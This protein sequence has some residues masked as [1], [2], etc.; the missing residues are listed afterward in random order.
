MIKECH[1]MN[2]RIV[3]AKKKFTVCIREDAR[4]DLEELVVKKSKTDGQ[5]ITITDYLTFLVQK[6]HKQINKPMMQPA[7]TSLLSYK[8][9]DKPEPKETKPK[10]SNNRD[11]MKHAKY[12][13]KLSDMERRT[14][15]QLDES[16][17]FN[18][19]NLADKLKKKDP[20]RTRSAISAAASSAKFKLGV[21]SIQEAREIVKA[22]YLKHQN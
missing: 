1:N 16:V 6:E 7:S 4:N 11:P 19:K 9:D 2:R 13:R 10:A 12:G 21:D 20:T 8:A 18:P 22:L 5:P 15:L 14:I 17:D 3:L